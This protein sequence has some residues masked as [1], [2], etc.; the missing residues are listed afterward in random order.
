MSNL[1]G[2]IGFWM[3]VFGLIMTLSSFTHAIRKWEFYGDCDILFPKK[4]GKF[5][6][7]CELVMG[8]HYTLM[9]FNGIWLILLGFWPVVYNVSAPYWVTTFASLTLLILYIGYFATRGHIISGNKLK[10]HQDKIVKRHKTQE[11]LDEKDDFDIDFKRAYFKMDNQ[12]YIA[13][14]WLLIDVILWF[15]Y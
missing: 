1:I 10:E 5:Q 4:N 15:I 8:L 2:N 13:V 7:P 12:L 14:L 3:F 11:T 9:T 6:K